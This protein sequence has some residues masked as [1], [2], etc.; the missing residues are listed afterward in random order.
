MND[1]KSVEELKDVLSKVSRKIVVVRYVRFAMSFQ[2]FLVIMAGYYVLISPMKSFSLWLTV[3]YWSVSI[4]LFV[5][6]SRA[7]WK[8]VYSGNKKLQTCITFSWLLSAF[9]CWL[10]APAFVVPTLFQGTLQKIAV[11]LLSFV[12]LA[13]FLMIVSIKVFTGSLEKLMLPAFL[14]PALA[15]PLIPLCKNPVYF[16]GMNIALGYGTTVLLYLTAA[17]SENVEELS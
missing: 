3:A 13:V 12:S 5:F 6:I 4:A 15:I 2:F 14:I 1:V 9:F 8:K 17:V 7:M 10:I 11:S 16:A